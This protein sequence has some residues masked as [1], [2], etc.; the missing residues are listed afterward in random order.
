MLTRRRAAFTASLAAALAVT[1]LGPWASPA[2][3]DSTLATVTA[4]GVTAD[5]S[6]SNGATTCD[7]CVNLNVTWQ[8]TGPGVLQI[9]ASAPGGQDPVYATLVSNAAGTQASTLQVC[10]ETNGSGTFTVTGTFTAGGVS[11]PLPPNVSFTVTVQAP[12]FRS[13]TAQQKGSRTTVAGQLLV[14]TNE[15]MVGATGAVRLAVRVAGSS[16]SSRWTTLGTIPLS[17]G[18]GQF[19]AQYP[20]TK[21]PRGAT[22]RATLVKDPYCGNTSQTTKVR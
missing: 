14:V 16:G 19:T 4:S 18:Y 1:V 2:R 21:V 22:V 20:A 15:G 17:Q 12:T 13:F 10:P 11:T 9:Q 3:A 6:F 8:T 7:S 5:V